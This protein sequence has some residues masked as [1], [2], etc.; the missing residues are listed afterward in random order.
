VNS[1]LKRP[2]RGLWRGIY[3]S[4]TSHPDY[5]GLSPHARLTILTLRLGG[6]S[7]LPGIGRVYMDALLAETGLTR[8][9]LKAA[10]DELE[11]KPSAKTPWIVRD[12]ALLWVR[13]ALRFDPNLTFAN[14]NHVLGVLRAVAALPRSSVVVQRFLEYYGLPEPD[15][16]SEEATHHPS[17]PPSHEG[18][19]GASHGGSGAVEV[20]VEV[21]RES[22]R[23]STPTPR[24]GGLLSALK[25]TTEPPSHDDS[26]RASVPLLQRGAYLEAVRRIEAKHPEWTTDQI[27]TEAL[28][29][30]KESVG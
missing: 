16:T 26:S 22:K 5:V 12:G 8:R 24:H 29:V 23:N 9:Q 21:L 20:A 15:Q 28:K 18:R 3:V 19:D 17:H 30:L 1:G 27:G 14:P 13:N 7:T 4:M 11:R 25:G 10:L 2:G 6:Q